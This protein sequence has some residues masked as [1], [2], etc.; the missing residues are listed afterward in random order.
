MYTFWQW[1]WGI[2]QTAAGA[3]LYLLNRRAPH[4]KFH[5][6]CVTVWN[7]VHSV[8]LGK[9]IFISR[10]TGIDRAYARYL[11]KHEYGHTIQS[12]ILGPLYLPLIGLPSIIWNR[13]PY[14]RNRRYR[15][16]QSYYSVIFERTA[17][18]L[19]ERFTDN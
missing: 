1:T 5:G 10:N 2:I 4:F 14:F 9:F 3:I 12:L 13:L 15:T 17:S 16:G 19:G 11:L 18:N 6:A 7:S 8:S